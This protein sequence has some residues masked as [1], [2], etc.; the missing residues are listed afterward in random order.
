MSNNIIYSFTAI[1]PDTGEI[2]NTGKKV[3]WNGWKDNAYRYR[4]KAPYVRIFFDANYDLKKQELALFWEIC[5]LMN[6][7]N[8]LV[9]KVQKEKYSKSAEYEPLT[10]DDIFEEVTFSR[11]TFMRAWKKLNGKYIKKIKVESMKVWAVNPAFA[12]KGDYL[13]PFLYENFEEYLCPF[14]SQITRSKFNSIL[15]DK[16]LRSDNN[17]KKAS[18]KIAESKEKDE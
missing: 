6:K 17:E 4:Y 2:V 15:L 8:L 18:K 5:R 16:Q 7:D 14:L 3:R 1:D 11:S 10:R 12:M 9:R 13:E